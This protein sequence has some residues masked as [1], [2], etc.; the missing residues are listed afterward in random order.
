MNIYV[1]NLKTSHERLD[2]FL[3]GFPSILEKPSVWEA[4]PPEACTMP[5]W[6][7]GTPAFWSH[8]ENFCDVLTFTVDQN[9]NTLFFEDDCI[10][11]QD[12]EARWRTFTQEVPKDADVWNLCTYHICSAS[13]PPIQVT[14]NVL[15]ATLGF[16]TNAMLIT[17]TGASKI[18]EQLRRPSWSCKHICE[19]QLGYLYRDP[20]FIAY[21]PM[22]NF[23]GQRACYSE[24]CKRDR[25]ERWYNRF[26]YRG[27]D[28]QRHRSEG[29]YEKE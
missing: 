11:A 24:L 12:F 5:D 15:R 4:K 9:E 21:A 3:A 8:T 27:Q 6:W 7:Q 2:A 28:G 25:E 10:F 26:I 19:Q 1:L 13:C 22:Q 17:P 14:P 23:I 16:N 20:K 29:L 18:L